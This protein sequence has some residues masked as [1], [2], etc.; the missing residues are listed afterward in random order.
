MRKMAAALCLFLAAIPGAGCGRRISSGQREVGPDDV[1][2]FVTRMAQYLDKLDDALSRP[3]AV[4]QAGAGQARLARQ[5]IRLAR[6]GL[7]EIEEL[8]ESKEIEDKMREV[9]EAFRAAARA[10]AE[11]KNGE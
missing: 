4:P 5:S 11:L 7:S 9:R 3:A 8:T 10:V 1:P 2:G 6:S